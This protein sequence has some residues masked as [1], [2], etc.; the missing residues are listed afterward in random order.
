VSDTEELAAPLKAFLF[1]CI[2]S[3]EQIEILA[4]LRLSA[5]PQ[6]AHSVAAT[7][8]SSAAVA[9]HHLETLAARGLLQVVTGEEVRYRFAPKSANLSTYANQVLD[10]YAESR[11][12]VLRAIAHTNKG[13]LRSFLDAFKLRGPD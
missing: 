9:R 13:S 11:M 8:A 12:P 6:S 10:I 4:T 7:L 2:D 1:A 5:L 3:I